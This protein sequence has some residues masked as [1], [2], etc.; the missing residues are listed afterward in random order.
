MGYTGICYFGLVCLRRRRN[1]GRFAGEMSSR[2][3]VS[4]D[5]VSNTRRS[6]KVAESDLAKS[7]PDGR[8]L[9]AKCDVQALWCHIREGDGVFVTS[10]RNFHKVTKKSRLASKAVSVVSVAPDEAIGTG[11][12]SKGRRSNMALQPTRR[13]AIARRAG[14]N[15]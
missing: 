3:S 6:A 15:V 1:R 13:V 14:N 9:N 10:D 2:D 11:V 12:A 4:E 8:W 7:R 5:R